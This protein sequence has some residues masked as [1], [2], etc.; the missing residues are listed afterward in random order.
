MHRRPTTRSST[1]ATF[2][3][4]RTTTR[5]RPRRWWLSTSTTSMSSTGLAQVRAEPRRAIA[6]CAPPMPAVCVPRVASSAAWL[7]R[8]RRV[9]EPSDPAAGRREGHHREPA[10]RPAGPAAG[11][12]RRRRRGGWPVRG[13]RR[14]SGGQRNEGRGGELVHAE[15]HAD[16]VSP[17]S[18]PP[19][20]RAQCPAFGLCDG[21]P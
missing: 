14:S 19:S 11:E 6:P 13:H 5:R 17:Q 10:H 8:V 4:R 16:N 3:S 1:R 21:M 2:S 18:S 7:N 15:V 9:R 12:R 20:A